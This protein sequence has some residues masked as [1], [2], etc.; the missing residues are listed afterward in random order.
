MNIEWIESVK[1]DFMNP[2]TCGY[3]GDC[4]IQE[5]MIKKLDASS[6]N[7]NLD[8]MLYDISI[9]ICDI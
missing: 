8:N 6:M 4:L 3:E 2:R 5:N 1:I 7:K 9:T